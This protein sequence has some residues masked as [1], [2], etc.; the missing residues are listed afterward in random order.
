MLPLVKE[1]PLVSAKLS[2]LPEPALSLSTLNVTVEP[3]EEPT[4]APDVKVAVV[5]ERS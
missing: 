2:V 4:T 1:R 5:L 3:D